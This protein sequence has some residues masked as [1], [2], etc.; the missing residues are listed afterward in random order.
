MAREPQAQQSKLTD[1]KGAA[2]RLAIP[3]A[4]LRSLVCKKRIPHVRL[5]CRFVRFDLD[6]LDK[7]IE[8]RAV[9]V[10]APARADE[11]SPAASTIT[12][13]TNASGAGARRR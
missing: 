1:Y 5:G 13:S 8:E 2:E 9:S 11:V 3:I 10:A 12:A 7:W 4:T 6:A